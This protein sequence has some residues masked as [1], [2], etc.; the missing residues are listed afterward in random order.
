MAAKSSSLFKGQES[1][2]GFNASSYFLPEMKSTTSA[3][4]VL[5]TCDCPVNINYDHI[6]GVDCNAVTNLTSTTL[7]PS[8]SAGSVIL[9]KGTLTIDADYTFAP[10]CIIYMDRGASI[11]IQSDKVLTLDNAQVQ[12][13]DHLWKEIYVENDAL[14]HLKGSTG[15]RLRDAEYAVHL[16]DKSNLWME[17]G[18][19]F[20]NNY[21]GVFFDLGN[22][23][24]GYANVY[25]FR[26]VRFKG[27]MPLKPH[28]AET[29]PP[30][31]PWAYAGMEFH[32]MGM[33]KVGEL[34]ANIAGSAKNQFDNLRNGLLMYSTNLELISS[35]FTNIHENNADYLVQGHGVY[36]YGADLLAVENGTKD[37]CTFD[38]C[39]RG[40]HLERG[41]IDVRHTEMTNISDYGIGVFFAMCRDIE[42]VSNDISSFYRGIV[43]H[44]NDPVNYLSINQN[45]LTVNDLLFSGKAKIIDAIGANLLP[46]TSASISLNTMTGI[47]AA[48]GVYM[49][50]IDGYVL[51]GNTVQM[52]RV[53]LSGYYGIDLFNSNYN[54]LCQ[55]IIT[56]DYL[57]NAQGASTTPSG[58]RMLE[59]KYTLLE[60][61]STTQNYNGLLVDMSCTNSKVRTT[62]FQDSR[63][64][65]HYLETGVTGKQ[66]ELQELFLHG[67]R[68]YGTWT[69]AENGAKH[70]SGVP[71]FVAMSQY[72]VPAT[73]PE[74][75]PPNV[76]PPSFFINDSR[77]ELSCEDAYCYG[78]FLGGGSNPG[79][80][81]QAVVAGLVD[82]GVYSEQVSWTLAGD[83]Y[84]EL[85]DHPDWSA[86]NP[87][88]AAFEDSLSLTTLGALVEWKRAIPAV[89][90]L[91]A[92]DQA[93]LD[94]YSQMK[95]SLRLVLADLDAQLVD[96]STAA[97]S[98]LLY[99]ERG[100]LLDVFSTVTLGEQALWSSIEQQ[101]ADAASSLLAQNADLLAN[102]VMESNAITV[103][104]I[105]L[106]TLGQGVYAL[107]PAQ[108]SDLEVVASQCPYTGGAPVFGA[109]A[110][111]AL[112]GMENVYGESSCSQTGEKNAMKGGSISVAFKQAR[113]YPNPAQT[114]LT[115]DL[116]EVLKAE[117]SLRMLNA[118]GQELSVWVM[119]AGIRVFNPA[120]PEDIRDGIYFL[121]WTDAATGTKHS[122]RISVLK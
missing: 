63:Y 22:G 106:N 20:I 101:R 88:F 27:N 115:V 109:R 107:S 25:P 90:A 47:D 87:A 26:G 8:V 67:N 6:V 35:D 120:L 94:N 84:A 3:E 122:L 77:P 4:E 11:V 112:A 43:L 52:S 66:P 12:G 1:C 17:Q 82:P 19:A 33:L 61:N 32:N 46:L 86:A 119:P 80:L 75:Y 29:N 103:Y 49:K 13:C 10:N 56:G 36:V 113:A 98:L 71:S 79:S 78:E 50:A 58:I 108:V 76:N 57:S 114:H 85:L 62:T 30:N 116:G 96:A 95:D 5:T 73:P 24:P 74:A 100:S 15:T 92:S 118:R 39:D 45:S 69:A 54:K 53:A 83:V 55:N 51:D 37:Q 93:T 104:G 91:S 31:Y 14:L 7:Y 70:E 64:G 21:V 89:F 59:A 9:I 81:E 102:N 97:D 44:D 105:L 121:H 34:D 60:C 38:Q 18:T 68:W 2:Y 110:L 41:N 72:Y 23:I 65:L 28:Y 111:L 40:I 99:A 16:G 42:M 48:W 117:T